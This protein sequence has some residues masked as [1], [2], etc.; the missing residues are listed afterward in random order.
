[1]KNRKLLSP[2][3]NWRWPDKKNIYYLN[4]A[5]K[6]IDRIKEKEIILAWE[7]AKKAWMLERQR[8]IDRGKK[9]LESLQVGQWA[10]V[11]LGR[12][13]NL[14]VPLLNQNLPEILADYG[15]IV[16][17]QEMLWDRKENE[18][19]FIHWHYGQIIMQAARRAAEDDRL[20]PIFITNFR[21]SPDSFILTYFRDL[22]ER[23]HKPYPS[24]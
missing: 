8:Q 12:P 16:L 13:Y 6:K 15:L 7:M 11:V 14:D 5:L 24:A 10:V 4:E 22:M 23:A 21:C 18:P 19:D 20:F 9:I 3:I 17:R 1:M 2:L